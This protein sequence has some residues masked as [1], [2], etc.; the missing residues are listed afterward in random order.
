MIEKS[1]PAAGA[2]TDGIYQGQITDIIQRADPVID[3][4]VVM[5]PTDDAALV[6]EVEEELIDRHDANLLE[7]VFAGEENSK[8]I[9]GLA[10]ELIAQYEEDLRS[11]EPWE[12]TY[13]EGLKL[14]GLTIEEKTEP[15]EGACAVVHPLLTEA[16]V[17]FQS[18]T[19]IETFPAH[20]PVKT[21]IVGKQTPQ[22]MAA[23]DRVKDDMNWRLTD[24]MPEYRVEH[25]RL[26]WSLPIA[27]AAFKKVYQD[28]TL[29]RQASMFVPAED[30]V[31]NYGASD[32]IS[33]ERVTHVM[34]RSENWL[35]RMIAAGVYVD[36]D[37]GQPTN[38]QSDIDDVKDKVIG[39]DSS[40]SDQY[41]ILEMLVDL[42]IEPTEE[43]E[44][45][46]AFAWPYVVTINTA[47]NRLMA[48]RRNWQEGDPIKKK[49]Q[50]FVHYNY[51]PGFGFY[52]FGL[53]HLG[54]VIVTGK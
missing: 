36:E 5:P 37:I 4:E 30:L 34:R 31:V 14:L 48:I 53:V 7:T 43:G 54:G 24:E 42:I 9:A 50:H 20:G 52:G 21:Q 32:I 26:L 25:E 19:I 23:A 35:K 29:G 40:N 10:T 45:E 11:R 41:K 51:I 28:S 44:D 16:V 27:G 15:W 38:T 49:L 17:K 8:N 2:I 22:K 13:K 46:Q 39:A 6:V 3:I 1:L 12:K 47:T 18:E 33:A